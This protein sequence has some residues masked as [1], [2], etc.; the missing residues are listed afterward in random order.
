MEQITIDV[1]EKAS[2]IKILLT[3]CDAVL[4][5]G[6]VYYSKTGEEMKLF[7]MRDGMGVERLQKLVNV[8]TGIVTGENSEIVQRRVDKLKI[9]EYHP[10]SRDKYFTLL[11]IIKRRGISADQVAY[12][13]DDANDLEIMRHVGLSAC[14]SDA[15]PMIMDITHLKMKN[16]GGHGA[17]REFAEVIIN[18][19]Q[20]SKWTLK[21][22]YW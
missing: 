11:E 10:G 2:K 6:C 14:P 8:E 17:F 9:K 20:K 7:S 4:T 16:K 15:M 3:D 18:F 21:E 12:I 13:G 1:T 5:D 22:N 19:K